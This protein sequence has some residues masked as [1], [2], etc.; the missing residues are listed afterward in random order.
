MMWSTA[1]RNEPGTINMAI[2]GVR[3]RCAGHCH[4]FEVPL[5]AL[6][7][8][9]RDAEHARWLYGEEPRRR[10][11]RRARERSRNSD[12]ARPRPP[13]DA[14][15]LEQVAHA[16]ERGRAVE[17]RGHRAPAS[18]RSGELGGAPRVRAI[19]VATISACG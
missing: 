17:P 5:E 9:C 16:H 18:R 13:I 10:L 7:D 19:W 12:T 3:R 8:R 14:A 2:A 11:H 15:P 4:R 6:R 1:I